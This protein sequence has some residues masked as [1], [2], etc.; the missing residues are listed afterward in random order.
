MDAASGAD[1]GV[2]VEP[3]LSHI[4]YKILCF[5]L[6]QA[7]KKL[8]EQAKNNREHCGFCIFT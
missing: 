5:L 1:G 8:R 2:T 4:K 7:P 3:F 6:I